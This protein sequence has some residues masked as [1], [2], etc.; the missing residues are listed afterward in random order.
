[1][2]PPEK[3]ESASKGAWYSLVND[4]AGKPAG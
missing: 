3:L 2:M 4:A 1:V